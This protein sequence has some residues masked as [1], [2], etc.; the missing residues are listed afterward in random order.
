[1]CVMV[2]VVQHTYVTAIVIFK[3][4]IYYSM[5]CLFLNYKLSVDNQYSIVEYIGQ[6]DELCK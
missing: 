4:A 6:Y 1:M 5:F 2:G 3:L